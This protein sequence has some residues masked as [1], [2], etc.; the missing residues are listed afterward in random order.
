ML[1][2]EKWLNITRR[3]NSF[4]FLEH[5]VLV[6][7]ILVSVNTGKNVFAMAQLELLFNIL[8]ISANGT[9]VSR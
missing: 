6:F 2:T 5:F 9:Y 4:K 7:V 8:L 1:K 3:N